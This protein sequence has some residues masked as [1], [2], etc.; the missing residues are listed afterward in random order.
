[1]AVALN[2][3]VG[4][5]G[6]VVRIIRVNIT[7]GL[8]VRRLVSDADGGHRSLLSPAAG[9]LLRHSD[10]L[11][12]VDQVPYAGLAFSLRSMPPWGARRT[13]S[14]SGSTPVNSA[15]SSSVI[16]EGACLK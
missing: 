13:R 5:L 14:G 16:T 2:H 1:M 11:R 7:L 6:A 8:V 15:D 9:D 12:S 3:R 4:P 10:L